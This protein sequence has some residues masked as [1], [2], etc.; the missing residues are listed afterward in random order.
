MRKQVEHI[1]KNNTPEGW[2]PLPTVPG[3]RKKEEIMSVKYVN[4][5]RCA[6]RPGAVIVHA[7]KDGAELPNGRFYGYI[8]HSSVKLYPMDL[9]TRSNYK[10]DDLDITIYDLKARCPRCI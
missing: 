9:I 2:V 6:T 10:G 3:E 7:Y 4:M 1:K 8:K 5:G